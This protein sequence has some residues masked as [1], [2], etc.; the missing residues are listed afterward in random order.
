MLLTEVRVKKKKRWF[1][2]EKQVKEVSQPP[3]PAAENVNI[4]QNCYRNALIA[5]QQSSVNN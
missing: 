3:L 2:V 4:Y 5:W 1:Q